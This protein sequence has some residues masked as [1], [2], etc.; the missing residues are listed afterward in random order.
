MPSPNVSELLTAGI[1]FRAGKLGDSVTKNIALTKRLKSKGR[2]KKRSG[3]TT[4]R[5]EVQY[6]E[7]GSY[8]R[9]NGA[10]PLDTT[11]Q[12][13]LT[14]YEFDWKQGAIFV[15]ITGREQKINSGKEQ[16]LDLLESRIENAEA[17][18]ANKLESD[19]FSDGTASGGKQIGGIQY[20]VADTPTSG[21][22]GGIS[23]STWSFA[24]NYA[25]GG[26]ADGGAAVSASNIQDYLEKVIINTTRG[27]D[28]ADIGFVDN[29]Y[30]SLLS[31]SM[32][33]IQRIVSADIAEGGFTALNFNG[34]DFILA[35]G[36][37]GAAP[38]AHAYVLN[39]NHLF[40]DYLGNSLFEPLDPGERYSYNQNVMG[41]FIGFMANLTCDC[42]FTNGVLKA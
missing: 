13:V 6:Q 2:I 26:V 19:L 38:T 16:I 39:S 34:V 29:S 8:I 40:L 9:F 14:S 41:K 1:E 22:V 31:A 15:Q 33:S 32:R 3:G 36:F 11:P 24:R 17:T 42:M 5:R 10:D 27:N 35:G 12:D 28:R 23:R 20:L 7:N 37:G 25:F 4:V 30:Y 21:T 18:L